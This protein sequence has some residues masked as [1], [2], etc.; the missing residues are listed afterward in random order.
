MKTPEEKYLHDPQYARLVD[1]LE[2]LIRQDQFTPSEVREAA[3]LACIRYEMKRPNKG[4]IK[5][6]IIGTCSECN[7]SVVVPETWA[8]LNPPIPTCS[9]CGAE[10][11]S[12]YGPKVPMKKKRGTC[13]PTSSNK[14][15]LK[16]YNMIHDP[17]E[18][19]W[20]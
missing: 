14:K 20:A 18:W 13:L 19:F 8:G 2:G 1:A 4:E 5:M 15:E 7:G 10:A 17:T 12:R 3:R 9:N 6:Q 16:K 11:K